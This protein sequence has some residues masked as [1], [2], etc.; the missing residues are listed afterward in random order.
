MT[1][2]GGCVGRRADPFNRA[3]WGRPAQVARIAFHIEDGQTMRMDQNPF[4]RK[5][6]VPWYD[7]DTAC[8][9]VIVCM[10]VIIFFGFTGVFAARETYDTPSRIWIPV[11]LIVLGAGVIL[12]TL[13]RL[14]KRY[15]HRYGK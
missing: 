6:I 5:I 1:R 13:I 12:S 10:A 15:L 2:F 3:D 7:S 4:F 14:L 9:I 11:L 8:Y